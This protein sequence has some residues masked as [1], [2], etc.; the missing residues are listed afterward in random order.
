[1][2]VRLTHNYIPE[3]TITIPLQCCNHLRDTNRFWC[4]VL[5]NKVAKNSATLPAK[6][7]LLSM[8]LPLFRH[9]R[10]QISKASAKKVRELQKD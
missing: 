3:N 5:C 1:M 7:L 10:V 4:D 9:P 6:A 2:S 8:N